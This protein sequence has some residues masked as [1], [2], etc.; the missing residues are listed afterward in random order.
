MGARWYDPGTAE[1]ISVDP[2]LAAME[3]FAAPMPTDDPVRSVRI[4]A[5]KWFPSLAL[6]AMGRQHAKHLFST[7]QADSLIPAATAVGQALRSAIG[8]LKLNLR[9]RHK[10]SS[11]PGACCS[12]NPNGSACKDSVA[13]QCAVN[14]A[15]EGF[16]QASSVLYSASR[17]PGGANGEP[18]AG[19]ATEPWGLWKLLWR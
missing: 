16:N 13:L 11:G 3:P 18:W 6:A 5:G 15:S 7:C 12:T 1:F 2:D 10:A 19:A 14:N 8:G 9:P 17:K 4:R